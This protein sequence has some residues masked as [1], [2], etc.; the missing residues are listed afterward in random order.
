M[1]HG[2]QSL[3]WVLMALVASS[4]VY[5]TDLR[6]QLDRGHRLLLQYGYQLH[7]YEDCAVKPGSDPIDLNRLRNANFNGVNL[8]SAPDWAKEMSTPPTGNYYW[9]HWSARATD[10]NLPSQQGLVM[11]SVSDEKD[12]SDPTVVSNSAR[13][14]ADFRTIQPNVIGFVTDQ[15]RYSGS[16]ASIK[17]YMAAAQPDMLFWDHYVFGGDNGSPNPWPGGSPTMLY[18]CMGKYR[19]AALAGNNGDFTKPI[20]YGM[21][22]QTYK[23][24]GYML[25][26]SELNVQYG[27]GWAY[28]YT[29]LFAFTYGNQGPGDPLASVFFSGVGDTNPTPLYYSV[30]R[31]NQQTQNLAPS[32]LRLKSV[33][34]QFVRGQHK[35]GFSTVTNDLPDYAT[36]WSVSTSGD[37][38]VTGVTA[39]NVGA[40]GTKKNGGLRGDLIVG[41]FKPLLEDFDGPNFSNQLYFMIT[42]GLT[43]TLGDR[44]VTRQL[45]HLTFNF[46]T[47]GIT[48]LQELDRDT[49][50]VLIVPLVYDG[51]SNYHLD[52][53]LYGG[54][55]DLFKYNTGAPFVIPEPSAA[56]LLLT[57]LSTMSLAA[58]RLRHRG[59]EKHK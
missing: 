6:S 36:Q 46:G 52:W 10:P 30:A 32:L 31:L 53:Y 8:G 42:N 24:N 3:C 20:P 18:T 19:T 57:L 38:Y 28:G 54:E 48:S 37:P 34:L 21:C 50:Q 13:W 22:T 4:P 33:N 29:S 7:A 43:D 15:G 55:G 39:T 14:L 11:A 1:R 25:S 12:L 16:L 45:V 23:V 17:N 56:A 44:L 41:Y 26:E 40:N 5:G 2:L 35:S 9:S 58:M 51:G 59:G 27:A 49:G 47:S